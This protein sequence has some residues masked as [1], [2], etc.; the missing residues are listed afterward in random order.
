M[1]VKEVNEANF[2]SEVVNSKIPV[3]VDFWAEWC[4]PCRAYSPI[5]DQTAEEMEGKVKVVKIN[6][7]DNQNLAS[8]YGVMSIPTTLLIVGG[9]LKA[10][11]VGAVPRE[12]LKQWI[13][14]NI[15]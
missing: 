5:I 13:T 11:N 15:P 10:A 7:D 4:G 6:V 8:K 14:K 3:V 12:A 9:K 2:D 1:A